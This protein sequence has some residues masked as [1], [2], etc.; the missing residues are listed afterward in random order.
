MPDRYGQSANLAEIT[1]PAFIEL[2]FIFEDVGLSD[3]RAGA[4]GETNRQRERLTPLA[5][6]VRRFVPAPFDA[7]RIR[8]IDE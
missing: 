6:G 3:R 1:D 2:A 5:D 7:K 4:D 8:A